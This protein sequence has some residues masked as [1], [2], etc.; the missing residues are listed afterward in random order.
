MR[1]RAG[2]EREKQT[3]DAEA[4]ERA[5]ARKAR[6]RKR[7][8]KTKPLT[9]GEEAAEEEGGEEDEDLMPL[10]HFG[11][12]SARL[13]LNYLSVNAALSD[14][15]G[16]LRQAQTL[17]DAAPRAESPVTALT[18]AT[19]QSAG[20]TDQA[21]D[22]LTA[23]LLVPPGT[24]VR[25]DLQWLNRHHE[26]DALQQDLVMELNDSGFAAATSVAE[27]I[28]QLSAQDPLDK[29]I[30]GIQKRFNMKPDMVLC[31]RVR[32]AVRGG[33]LDALAELLGPPVPLE[34]SFFHRSK[35]SSRVYEQVVTELHRHNHRERAVNYVAGISTEPVRRVEWYM[36]LGAPIMAVEA[37]YEGKDG[38]LIE[39][40]MRRMPQYERLQETGARLLQSLSGNA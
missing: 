15:E 30:D 2:D 7:G 18:A 21:A 3:A 32:G 19:G 17:Y 25:W 39:Q 23:T 40:V 35:V 14:A 28:E 33:Q 20:G 31:A 36:K 29:R 38:S 37:A 22:F 1:N 11:K 12:P 24:S 4:D 8:G 6:R 34:R 10:F 13:A 27:V 9:T 5:R 26:L 16:W